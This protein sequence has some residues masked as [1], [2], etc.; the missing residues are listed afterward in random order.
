MPRPQQELEKCRHARRFLESAH[1]SECC[2]RLQV[3]PMG[4]AR[5]GRTVPNVKARCGAMECRQG[6]QALK[7]TLRGFVAEREKDCL[8]LDARKMHKVRVK[9]RG[10]GDER[11]ELKH[12][13]AAEAQ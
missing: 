12:G 11:H 13:N 10:G 6:I 5:E 1:R 3:S 7:C 4:F 2:P 8:E 9:G